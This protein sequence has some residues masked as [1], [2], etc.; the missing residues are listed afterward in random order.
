LVQAQPQWLRTLRE[1]S[2]LV[3]ISGENWE[4]EYPTSRV[5]GLAV[6]FQG[7]VWCYNSDLGL[8]YLSSEGVWEPLPEE[9]RNVQPFSLRDVVYPLHFISNN[10]LFVGTYNGLYE[11]EL[12]FNY[13][14]SG[15]ISVYPNPFNYQRHNRLY[16]SARDLGGKDILIYD[17]IGDLKGKYNVPLKLTAYP[18]EINLS[19]G[20]YQYFVTSEGRVIHKGK[21]VVVR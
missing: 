11:F 17:I 3:Y 12:N 20:L 14:D 2:G 8:S 4:R 7:G 19:S 9:L 13:P 5:D 10:R 6:D 15:K 16:F 18:I 1:I 21:F